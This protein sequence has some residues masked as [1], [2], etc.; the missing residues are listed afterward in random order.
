MD[1]SVVSKATT[2]KA[3]DMIAE[4]REIAKIHPNMVVKIPMTLGRLKG[5]KGVITGRY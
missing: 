2:E 3:E 1:Q 4:G 5:N